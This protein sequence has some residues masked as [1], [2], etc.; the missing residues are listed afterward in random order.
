MSGVG[1]HFDVRG[2]SSVQS[3]LDG[4]LHGSKHGLMDSIGAEVVSQTVHRIRFEKATPQGEAWA[5]WSD[6]YAKTRTAGQSLLESEGHLVQ[7]MTHVVLLDG[8]G[9]DVG[10]NLIYARMLNDGGEEI[11]KPGFPA[12]QY[13]GFSQSNKQDIAQVAADWLDAQWS[14]GTLQ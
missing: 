4:M 14:G 5:P 2:L 10:S 6:R 9:V 12:R 7:S 8:E 11:G 13:L 3:R 1:L